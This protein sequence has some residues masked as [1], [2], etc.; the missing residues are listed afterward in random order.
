MEEHFYNPGNN[1]QNNQT[2]VML[3]LRIILQLKIFDRL[4]FV[5]MFVN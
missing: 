1:K 5:V 3:L 2:S 4:D